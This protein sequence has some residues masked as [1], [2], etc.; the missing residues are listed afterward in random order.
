MMPARTET[1]RY[2][3][4]IHLQTDAHTKVLTFSLT[5]SAPR[6]SPHCPC[7]LLNPQHLE[8]CLEHRGARRQLVRQRTMA[9]PTQPSA[10]H[11]DL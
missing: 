4:T 5:F 10:A 7:S 6:A 9:R 8:Q 3:D 1:V 11:D 2:K